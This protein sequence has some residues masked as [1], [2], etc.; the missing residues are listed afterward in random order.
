MHPLKG[1]K[2]T[3]E[4]IKK[5]IAAMKGKTR[6]PGSGKPANTHS[7]LWSKV[8]IRGNNECWP[9]KGF[10]NNQGYGRTWINDCGYYAHRVIFNLANPGVIDLRSP[11][12][13]GSHGFIM[14]SCDNPSCCN[15]DHLKVCTHQEN[16]DDKVAKGRQTKWTDSTNSP[17]AKLS[18]E[19]VFD[20]R[21]KKRNGATLKSIA[22]LYGVS[23]SSIS[24]CVYGRSYQD[25]PQ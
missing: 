11:K 8:D 12:N 7:V 9:W 22:L 21:I 1:K 5:R 10:R 24:H 25:V 19:D 13:K 6:K 23:R 15:P 14:H 3:E 2:Q 16:M 17:R 4:H 18:Q 20:I